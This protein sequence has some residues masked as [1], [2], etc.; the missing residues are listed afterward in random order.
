YE[1]IGPTPEVAARRADAIHRLREATGA[2]VVV[3][4]ALAA[5]QGL[6]PTSGAGPPLGLVAGRELAPDTL[7]DRLVDLGYARADLIEHRGE[8]AVRGGVGELFPAA[9][10]R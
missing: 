4:P 10:R 3:A 9:P 1:G 8:F 5:M 2:F 6:I 7:A